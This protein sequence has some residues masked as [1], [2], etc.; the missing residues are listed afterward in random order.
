MLRGTLQVQFPQEGRG[1]EKRKGERV[2]LAK[3]FNE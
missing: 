1:A 3:S 2:K